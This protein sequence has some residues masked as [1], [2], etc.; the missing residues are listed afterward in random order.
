L[1]LQ[2][3]RRRCSKWQDPR[4]TR[5]VRAGTGRPCLRSLQ[6]LKGA[7]TC[8]A[9]GERKCR[10][11]AE[12]VQLPVVQHGSPTAGSKSKTA[13]RRLQRSDHQPRWRRAAAQ[14]LRSRLRNT[15]D[16]SA[17]DGDTYVGLRLGRIAA[18]RS[19][20]RHGAGAR[21]LFRDHSAIARSPAPVETP[22]SH[23]R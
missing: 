22:L 12:V 6:D 2:E 20:I 1:G 3:Q 16:I 14:H 10:V 17:A 7:A 13:Q 4:P 11:K 21:E 18:Q 23:V 15:Y 19:C 9:R 8:V 5:P